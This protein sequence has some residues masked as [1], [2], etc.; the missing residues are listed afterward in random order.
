MFVQARKVDHRL[1]VRLQAY[2]SPRGQ[3]LGYAM[4]SMH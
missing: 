3:R 4:V 2:L 1:Q